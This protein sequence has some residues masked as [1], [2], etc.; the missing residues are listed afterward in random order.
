MKVI[1]KTLVAIGLGE[2]FLSDMDA[3]AQKALA[4]PEVDGYFTI[5]EPVVLRINDDSTWYLRKL[6]RGSEGYPNTGEGFIFGAGTSDI[7]SLVNDSVRID[8][9]LKEGIAII[10]I[11]S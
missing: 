8:L 2:E 1:Q 5:E 9:F 3:V 7:T 4:Q 11:T 10:N 6:K